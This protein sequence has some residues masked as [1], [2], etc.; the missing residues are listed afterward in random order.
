MLQNVCFDKLNV[1]CLC[2]IVYACYMFL[3]LYLPLLF[4]KNKQITKKNNISVISWRSDLLVEETGVP[5]VFKH[6]NNNN[7]HE[8]LY[9]LQCRMNQ[10]IAFLPTFDIFYIQY[11]YIELSINSM[12][13]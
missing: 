7:E 1:L 11:C 12:P 5:L 13:I 4:F 3:Y 9:V 6:H 10:T 8:Y 2:K